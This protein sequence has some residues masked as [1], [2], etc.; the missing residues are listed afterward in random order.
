MC[1]VNGFTV[2][3][4]TFIP[5]RLAQC[6]AYQCHLIQLHFTRTPI[7][8]QIFTHHNVS[9]DSTKQHTHSWQKITRILSNLFSFSLSFAWWPPSNICAL[10]TFTCEICLHNY[11]NWNIQANELSIWV[12]YHHRCHQKWK[13][14]KLWNFFIIIKSIET[15]SHSRFYHSH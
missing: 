15:R 12:N 6:C 7:S 13:Q 5:Y 2:R 10:Q 1:T 8:Q 11:K 4:S 14:V 9:L 3:C